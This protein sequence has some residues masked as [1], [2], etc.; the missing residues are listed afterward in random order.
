MAN[1]YYNNNTFQIQALWFLE[2]VL[3]EHTGPIEWRRTV[4]AQLLALLG[5][6][7]METHPIDPG[8]R[9]HN[10][11]P[12]T[13]DEQVVGKCILCMSRK[14]LEDNIFNKRRGNSYF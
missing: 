10:V 5:R 6:M 2:K 11:P 1:I 9:S 7:W 14:Y 4:C 3:I 13:S 12:I 8:L